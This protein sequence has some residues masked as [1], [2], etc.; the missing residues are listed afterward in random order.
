MQSSWP[1]VLIVAAACGGG[2]NNA[3]DAGPAVDAPPD[4][5]VAPT[6]PPCANPVNGTTVHLRELD[7][8]DDLGVLVTAPVGD[9]RLFVVKRRGEI[10]IFDGPEGPLRATPFLDASDV[11][12]QFTTVGGEQG[13]LGLAFH[14]AYAAN[15]L[16]YIYATREVDGVPGFQFANVVLRCTRSAADENR[17]DPTSCVEILSIRDNASN[18]NGGMIE[19]GPDG[20]LYISTGDGGSQDDPN[21][22]G[23]ALVDGA[24]NNSTT[25]LLGKILRIDVDKEANGKRYAIP[26]DNPFAGGGGAPEIFALGLRNPWRWSFDRAN[27]DVWIGDVG[28]EKF[29]EINYVPAGQLKSAN[30]GW[31]QFEAEECFNAPCVEA[32]KRFPQDIRLRA[33]GWRA[34]IG[35]EVYRGTCYPD[36]VGTFFYGD[37]VGSFYA[38]A[39]VNGDGTLA[40][41][42]L[43]PPQGETF[44]ANPASIHADARGEIYVTTGN[45]GV[46]HLEASP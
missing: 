40:V 45:G 4:V 22:N 29:E 41:T 34:I 43:A 24:F 8:L 3:Q 19:F 2:G 15:G 28:Q 9:P 11:V 10:E 14:P 36:L 26:A 5:F 44:P 37:S 20:F 39:T 13:L 35:G 16:F 42:D 46:F 30:F 38:K 21:R 18:H 12:A 17:A 23:Q 32:G 1:F 27:G 33:D 7:R 6:L 31:S 25:A